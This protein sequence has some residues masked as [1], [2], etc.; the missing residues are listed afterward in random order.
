MLSIS[1]TTWKMT[2]GPNWTGQLTVLEWEAISG[3]YYVFA[4]SV[5]T[6]QYSDAQVLTSADPLIYLGWMADNVSVA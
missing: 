1:W 6:F 5:C 4:D 3:R 2:L